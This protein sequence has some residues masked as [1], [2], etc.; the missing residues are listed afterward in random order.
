MK[1][2]AALLLL[3]LLSGCAARSGYV[4]QDL[5]ILTQPITISLADVL[6]DETAQQIE[7]NNWTWERVC[8]D[9]R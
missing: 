1:L 7:V 4:T 9:K 8:E 3:A 2:S 5:C 6:T